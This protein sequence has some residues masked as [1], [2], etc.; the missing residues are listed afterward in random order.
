MI[1]VA[2]HGSQGVCILIFY[3]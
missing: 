2:T 3:W 1:Y